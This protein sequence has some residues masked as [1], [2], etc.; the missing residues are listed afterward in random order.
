MT[1]LSTV[2]YAYEPGLIAKLLGGV[3]EAAHAYSTAV[4]Y[5]VNERL[6][7]RPTNVSVL[8][9]AHGGNSR[10]GE[11][12]LNKKQRAQSSCLLRIPEREPVNT[13]LNLVGTL[14]RCGHTDP[15]SV[16]RDRP[17]KS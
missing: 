3:I 13:T 6:C 14:I 4:R 12:H 16:K 10:R 1:K 9:E 2:P 5:C 15:T 8:T 17:A 11:G 7:P